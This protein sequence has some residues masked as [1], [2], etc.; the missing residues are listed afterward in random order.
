MYKNVSKKWEEQIYKSTISTINIYIDNVLL[1]S[2]NFLVR[3]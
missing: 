2:D 1:D 3:I